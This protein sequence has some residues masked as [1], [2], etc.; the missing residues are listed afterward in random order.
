MIEV[1]S[2]SRSRKLYAI[3]KESKDA[4]ILSL[5]MNEYEHLRPVASS[6][7]ANRAMLDF[8][9]QAVKLGVAKELD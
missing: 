9:R 8:V 4:K 1:V 6:K 3:D 5:R 2:R 7:S